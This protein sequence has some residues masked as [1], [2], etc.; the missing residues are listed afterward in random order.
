MGNTKRKTKV[1]GKLIIAG[2][3]TVSGL[4]AIPAQAESNAAYDTSVWSR[5]MA[6]KVELTKDNT[7]PEIDTDF[8]LVAPDHWVWDTWPLQNRDGSL[9]KIKGYRVAFALVAPRNL[10]WG[11]RHTEARIGMFTSK[12]GKDW[13]Y[14]GIPYEYEEALGHMQWAGSAMLDEE[15]KVHFFYTATGEKENWQQDNWERTAPQKLAKTTFDI[16]ADKEGV[17]LTNEGEHEIMLEAD[18]EYYETIEQADSPI[19]TAF[20]DPYFFQDP[21]TGKEYILFEGQTGD[22]YDYLKP[23]NIGDEE[24]RQTADVPAGAEK[25]NGNIGIAEVTDDDA[26]ELEMMPP[27]LESIGTNHQ[28]ERPHMVVKD[29]NYYLFTISHTFTYAPGLTGPD[30]VYGFVS[31]EGM[32]GDYEPMNESGLVIANP[33]DNPYQAYSWNIL[34]DFQVISFINEPRDENGEVQFGGTFAPT[35]QI[36]VDGKTSTITEERKHGEIKPF[37]SYSKQ[38]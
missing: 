1:I 4:T 2:V 5:Q 38:Y 9:A 20:R 11:A 24:Y 25:Y 36:E 37:G 16:S 21:A 19:I 22:N 35:L 18:G 13:T 17:H 6:E 14:Q 12:N 28:M 33:E 31:E 34:P 32:F 3:L 7:A 30:G 23:E 27:L 29:G 15:G 8:D 10:G 26:S